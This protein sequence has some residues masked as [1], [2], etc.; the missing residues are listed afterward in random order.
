MNATTSDRALTP[1]NWHRSVRAAC[2]SDNQLQSIISEFGIPPFWRRAPGW[3]T[4]AQIILEQQV[5]LH[6]G[7]QAWLRV[8]RV[9]QPFNAGRVV[10]VGAAPLR[11]AGVT[12]Q[13]A[14]YL[15][16]L[17]EA[18]TTGEFQA[19]A[20]G[21]LSN[22]LVRERLCAMRGIGEWSANCY[23]LLAMCRADVWPDGDIALQQVVSE[24]WGIPRHGD[25]SA[26]VAGFKPWRSVAARLLWHDYLSR[27]QR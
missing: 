23:L 19:A 7:R 18:V 11:R 13:K 4:L 10:D 24:R 16:D 21:R 25:R 12:R 9:V 1:T 20:L 2:A 6:S 3:Q 8:R 15:V 14:A 27:R 22:E 17:A 26:L 5:S